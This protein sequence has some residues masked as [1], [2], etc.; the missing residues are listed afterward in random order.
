MPEF[1]PPWEWVGDLA[2]QAHKF[3]LKINIKPNLL[4]DRLKE[5]LIG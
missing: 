1:H 2:R 5:Y 3:G 4:P